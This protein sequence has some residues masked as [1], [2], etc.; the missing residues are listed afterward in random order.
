MLENEAITL[1]VSSGFNI[2][3]EI[4]EI[5]SML[6]AC[7][8]NISSLIGKNKDNP[9]FIELDNFKN[10]FASENDI[11]GIY[12]I[13]KILKNNL[14]TLKV[15]ELITFFK[16]GK[17]I[18]IYKKLY[19]KI[20]K[21]FQKYKFTLNPPEDLIDDWNILNW[22][23]ENG[24]LYSKE[25]IGFKYWLSKSKY[26]S[27]M[28][29]KNIEINKNKILKLCQRHYLNYNIILKYLE[30]LINFTIG[31]FTSDK[32]LEKDY[33]ESPFEYIKKINNLKYILK[34]NSIENKITTSFILSN[35]L[36]IGLKLNSRDNRFTSIKDPNTKLDFNKL[37][38]NN[39]NSF[40]SSQNYMVFYLNLSMFNNKNI[41]NIIININPKKIIELFSYFY[42]P[43][44]I[45]NKYI[46]DYKVIEFEGDNWN[47]F[48]FL[49]KNNFD[50]NTFPLVSKEYL[51]VLYLYIKSMKKLIY[52]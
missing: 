4:M 45:K 37:F 33:E 47:N 9:K 12:K 46:I 15:F 5:L 34:D 40:V 43:D 27:V 50:L 35:P 11:L 21:K 51:P 3:I 10:L 31:Y 16:S 19:Q 22:L 30:V 7:N 2:E 26:F 20:V 48:I 1:L 52:Y 38:R 36:N 24:K 41:M 14:S 28:L 25:N 18:S 8:Y 42:N 32:D 49:V 23:K 39:L 44:R 6:T 29:S 13:C 17:Y